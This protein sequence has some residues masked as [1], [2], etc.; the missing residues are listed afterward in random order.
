[1]TDPHG[2]L[3]STAG[4]LPA[5]ATLATATATAT[6][7][8]LILCHVHAQRTAAHFMAVQA[9]DR[10][11]GAISIAHLHEAEATRATGLAIVDQRNGSH[12]SVLGE[13]GLDLGV[14]GTERK[15]SNIKL[16]Q[17]FLLSRWSQ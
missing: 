15:V 3:N 11:L 13:K 4:S 10:L 12:G 7:G 2:E 9:G 8:R 14:G 1:M 5:L 17:A 6:T 16:V